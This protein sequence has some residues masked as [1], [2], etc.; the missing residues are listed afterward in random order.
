MVQLYS[1]AALHVP[2]DLVA[3]LRRAPASLDPQLANLGD[4]TGPEA[5]LDVEFFGISEAEQRAA[6]A[7]FPGG[8]RFRL[9]SGGRSDRTSTPRA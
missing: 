8:R 6:L 3:N 9:V 7:A 4:M 2:P 5:E 1:F